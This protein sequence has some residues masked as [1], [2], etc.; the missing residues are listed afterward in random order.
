LK[1]VLSRLR[2]VS[3][4]AQLL[5]GSLAT[6]ALIVYNKNAEKMTHEALQPKG[7]VV[8]CLQLS[9]HDFGNF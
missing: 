7:S 4:F 6:D 8:E 9:G 2:A 1:C 5:R 3:G